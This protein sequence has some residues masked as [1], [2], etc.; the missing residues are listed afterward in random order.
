MN[1]GIV[2]AKSNGHLLCENC[3]TYWCLHVEQVVKD[4][5]DADPIWD[6]Y[7]NTQRI[8]VPIIPTSNLW[9]PVLLMQPTDAKAKMYKL[10]YQF[11]LTTWSNMGFI[12][13]GE[14]RSILRSMILEWFTGTQADD[15]KECESAGHGYHQTLKYEADMKHPALKIAQQWSIW[16]TGRCI[17]CTFQSSPDLVP[18]A[19]ANASPW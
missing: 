8:E 10:D 1:A 5:E 11:D 18:D 6:A 15:A 13:P 2:V 17:G 3:G 7:P 16:A 19:G 14:G 4:G 9:A 12:H